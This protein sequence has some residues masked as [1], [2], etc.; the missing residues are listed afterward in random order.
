M[1]FFTVLVMAAA[2]ALPYTRLGSVL[3]LVPLPLVYW[4]WIAGFLAA[5]CV[6]TSCMKTWFNRR[7][8]T[9]T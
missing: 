1:T 2:V 9:T 5:Y 3:G 6:L 8:G 4:I 7:F